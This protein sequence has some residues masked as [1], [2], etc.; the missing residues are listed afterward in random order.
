ME[1]NSR[2]TKI[3]ARPWNALS[4]S[5]I[6]TAQDKRARL[7]TQ[8]RFSENTSLKALTSDLSLKHNSTEH[9]IKLTKDQGRN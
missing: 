4:I 3:F 9:N 5:L 8:T 7:K 1:V 6:L 2:I